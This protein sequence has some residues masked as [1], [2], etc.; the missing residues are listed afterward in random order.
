[1]NENMFYHSSSKLIRNYYSALLFALFFCSSSSLHPYFY[2][3]VPCISQTC[4]LSLWYCNFC[5]LLIWTCNQ[6]KSIEQS[7]L[8]TNGKHDV[9]GHTICSL[10]SIHPTMHCTT[11]YITKR[12]KNQRSKHVINVLLLV[13]GLGQARALRRHHKQYCPS[14]GNGGT[15]ILIVSHHLKQVTSISSGC[16]QSMTCVLYLYLIFATCVYQYGW[17]VH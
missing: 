3:T 9:Q 16:V 4:P 5:S 1:M 13:F 14:W 8:L 7:V 6:S 12:D 17:H 15:D 11:V 10:Y 2:S